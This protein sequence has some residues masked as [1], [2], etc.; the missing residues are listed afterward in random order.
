MSKDLE[1]KSK[2]I[3]FWTKVIGLAIAIIGLISVLASIFNKDPA[4]AK[5]PPASL[6]QNKDTIFIVDPPREEPPAGSSINMNEGSSA[7]S[8]ES[9]PLPVLSPTFDTIRLIL[10]ARL[11]ASD[12]KVDGAPAILL[13][14]TPTIAVIRV[15]RDPDN[16]RIAVKDGA[17]NCEISTFIDGNKTLAINLEN[18]K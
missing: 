5:D 18:C 4:P 12:T 2:R 15:P 11:S 10:P 14:R 8:G 17:R 9:A 7:P 13:E 1:H 16:H 3:D 6:L